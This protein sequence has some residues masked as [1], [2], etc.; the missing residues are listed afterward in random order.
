MTSPF[1]GSSLLLASALDLNGGPIFSSIPSSFGMRLPC[2][3][4][5]VVGSH[6]I[7]DEGFPWWLDLDPSIWA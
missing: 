3:S 2:G 4:S 1:R 6:L 5:V 7:A